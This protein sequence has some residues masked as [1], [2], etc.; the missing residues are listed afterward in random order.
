MNTNHTFN[1]QALT[2]WDIYVPE[3]ARLLHDATGYPI[4]RAL[5]KVA[6]FYDE[7]INEFI[8][9]HLYANSDMIELGRLPRAVLVLSYISSLVIQRHISYL[10]LYKN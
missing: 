5:H 6:W 10:K 8:R 1:T 3:T 2:H 4:K 7:V 9:M